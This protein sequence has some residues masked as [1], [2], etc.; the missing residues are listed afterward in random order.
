MTIIAAFFAFFLDCLIGDPKSKLHP[1]VC[2]GRLISY[3]EKKLL[4]SENTPRHKMIAGGILVVCVL[5]IVYSIVAA[6]AAFLSELG[7]LA[8]WGGSALLLSFTISPR[9]LAE[10][11]KEIRALL[12]Q[13]DLDNARFKVGWI[14]GRDT[15]KL[16]VPEITR[17]TVETIA[18]NTV[19]GIIS[20]LFFFFI[21]GAPMAFLY[22]AVNTMDSMI[23]YK[24]DKYL[25]FGRVAARVDDCCNYIPARITALCIFAAAFLLRLDWRGSFCMVR[26][27]AKLHPSP[28][29]GFPEAAVAGALGIQ[30]GGINY[31]FGIAH[32][33]ARMGEPL[34]VLAPMHIT[35]TIYIMYSATLLFLFF[36]LLLSLSL[37][38]VDRS[39]LIF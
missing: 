32:H 20:P 12:L 9:S 5:S 2:I 18:E 35:K 1:V 10:A 28:N 6:M 24:N 19:D 16:D 34:H 21:G 7:P 37:G 29:G 36:A 3:M 31:Y 11:G 39:W 8:F 22:R 27:D 14:V 30:L 15:E 4:Q 26:R 38:K 33:R 13:N 17:A 23:A 25:Y